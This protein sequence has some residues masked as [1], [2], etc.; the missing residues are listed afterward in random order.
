MAMRRASCRLSSTV[1]RSPR[2][3]RFDEAGSAPLQRILPGLQVGRLEAELP[4]DRA[5]LLAVQVA[6]MQRVG[7]DDPGAALE[8]AVVEEEDRKSV[9]EGKSG[10]LGGRR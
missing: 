2:L 5:D 10:D 1:R 4:E 3:R 7:D 6:V 9:V 8:G